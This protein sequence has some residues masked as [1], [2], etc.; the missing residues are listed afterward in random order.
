MAS[1]F[2]TLA[3]GSSGNSAFLQV[4]G[5]GL[6]IDIGLQPRFLA[7]K[8]AVIGANWNHVHAVVLT[9]THS[10]HWKDRTLSQ[11]RQ[12]KIPIYCHPRHIEVLGNAGSFF[13]PLRKAGLVR[14]F[15]AGE[16]FRVGCTR[17]KAFP[18]P[19]DSNPTFAYHI[20]G[21]PGLFGPN[22]SIG[23]ASDLG[24]FPSELTGL[25][26]DVSLL[27]IE[28]NHD[29]QMQMESRRPRF[30]IE[31]V[32]SDH[33]HLSNLQAGDAVRAVVAN[34]TKGC[35]QHLVQ[36]HLS[37]ECNLP[38]LAIEEGKA[39]LGPTSSVVIHTAKQDIVGKAI[40]LE[41]ASSG[42]RRIKVGKT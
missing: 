31:R 4:N 14:H 11:L 19:H 25:F 42:A 27:A 15:E 5:F 37:K 34:S 1:R 29:V 10:D 30:L 21:P 22:W 6:L 39:A 36:L 12:L 33:G 20:E 41:P 35:L 26:Q 38:K 16:S 28:F 24:E 32:L 23:Y 2:V 7:E 3:S 8:L 17:V 13:E 18:V 9:H 40:D